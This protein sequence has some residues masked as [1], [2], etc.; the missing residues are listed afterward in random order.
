MRVFVVAN[1]AAGRAHAGSI[2][3]SLNQIARDRD[4]RLEVYE[5]TGDEPL[6]DLVREA[7]KEGAEMVFAAGGDGTVSAVVDGLVNTSVPLGIIPTGTGNVLAQ[8]LGI[9]LDVGRACQMLAGNPAT[10]SIDALQAGARFFVLSI[11]AGINAMTIKRTTPKRK[12]QLGPLAYVWTVLK[13]L[14]G[15]QPHTFTIVADGQRKRVR[16]TDVLLTNVA[17]IT[18][19]LRWG[20]HIRPDDGQIDICILRARNLLDIILAVWDAMVPDRP[21]RERNLRYWHAN[22]SILLFAAEPI[23]VQGDGE[24][25]GE[26]PIEAQIWPGAIDVLVPH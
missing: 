1:P 18:G 16:A 17:T 12:R 26:T 3:K 20:S 7:V 22:H 2:M 9:P 19:P 14:A 11:G 21:R 13:V 6:P 10:R 4:W 8:E 5:T 25:L 23:P 24:P 15:L